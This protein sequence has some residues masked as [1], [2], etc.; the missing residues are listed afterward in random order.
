MIH[1]CT[2]LAITLTAP[3][4]LAQSSD[5]SAGKQHS[6]MQTRGDVQHSGVNAS[7]EELMSAPVSL[8][9]DAEA[10]RE[11]REDGETAKRPKGEIKDLVIDMESG[12]V[13]W[14]AVSVGGLIGIGNKVALIETSSLYPEM[15]DGERCFKLSMT[16]QEIKNLPEFDASRASK[17]LDSTVTALGGK[18]RDGA[19]ASKDEAK[20]EMEA[21]TSRAPRH[22][23]A[24]KVVDC[25]LQA[26]DDTFGSVSDG[27][28]NTSNHTLTHLLVSRGGLAGLGD[29]IYIVPFEAVDVSMVEKEPALSVGRSVASLETCVVYEKPDEGF[30]NDNDLSQA[31]G[32]TSR[33]GTHDKK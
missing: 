11:A 12:K 17:D 31:T 23:L 28:M 2:A 27:V 16:E 15:V 10:R 33:M 22:M 9:P 26:T 19:Y 1:F 24:S 6:G 14:A 3:T 7:L 30:I 21:A 5:G 8:A 4:L 13:T 18:A 29:K 25:D 32:S 20:G